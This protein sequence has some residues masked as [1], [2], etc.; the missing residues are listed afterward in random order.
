MSDSGTETHG[1]RHR[2]VETKLRKAWHKERR[3]WHSRGV[4]HLALWAVAMVLLDFLVDWVFDFPG[5]GRLALLTVNVGALVWVAYR[6]WWRH[7]RAYNPARVALQVEGRHPELKSLLVSYV[8]LGAGS[9]AEA[10]VSSSL[11]QA[12]RRQAV[13]ETDPLNFKEIISYREL[14]RIF[15]FSMAVILVFAATSVNWP[16]YIGA[17]LHRMLNPGSNLQYPTRTQTEPITMDLTIRQGDAATVAVRASGWVPQR[18]TL[19]LKPQGSTT[20]QGLEVSQERGKRFSYRFDEVYESFEYYFKIGDARPQTF[21][22]TVV[23]PPRVV[24]ATVRVKYPAYT[25]VGERTVDRLNLEVLEG[26]EMQWNM[27]CDSPVSKAEMLVMQD[28]PV[29]L[30]GRPASRPASASASAAT[31]TSSPE[32]FTTLTMQ[33]DAAGLKA[34]SPVRT[35][36]DHFRYRFR[37]TTREPNYVYEED[38]EHFVQVMPDLPPEVE[39]LTPSTDQKATVFKTVSLSY[40]AIDDYGVAKACIVFWLNDGNDARVPLPAP[41]TATQ[42]A[43]QGQT[44]I[45]KFAWTLRNTKELSELKKGDI[46]TFGIEVTDNYPGPGGPHVVRSSQSRRVTIVDL[47]EYRKYIL[48]ALADLTEEIKQAHESETEGDQQVKLIKDAAT[49]TSAPTSQPKSSPSGEGGN[50]P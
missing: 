47:A 3:Y 34:T 49:T 31:S 32:P 48:E 6:Q 8:Q 29:G 38:V 19:Y 22:V 41:A 42:P 1:R 9:T 46:V 43:T 44:G 23:P 28:S 18:G 14:R 7:L 20:W 11:I 16:E 39:I 25:N 35:A 45:E 36:K 50:R 15:L 2:T 10:Y 13:K 26:A 12:L 27:R 5:P 37:W 21:R 33:L 24:E 40:R 30:V 4:C 17:L